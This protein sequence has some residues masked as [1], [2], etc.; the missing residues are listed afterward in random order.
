MD[1]TNHINYK[2]KYFL[3]NFVITEI[4]TNFAVIKYINTFVNLNCI[5]QIFF[6]NKEIIF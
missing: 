3:I 4:I 6:F 5:F 2:K 1:F